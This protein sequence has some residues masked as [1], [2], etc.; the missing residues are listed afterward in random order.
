[1]TPKKKFGGTKQDVEAGLKKLRLLQKEQQEFE[2]KERASGDIKL[3]AS[4]EGII[5]DYA[6]RPRILH[7]SPQTH[8][9]AK[10][11]IIEAGYPF[12]EFLRL[13]RPGT[14]CCISSL[15]RTTLIELGNR[16]LIRMKKVRSPGA[17][18]GIVLIVRKS[19]TDY[20]MSSACDFNVA[21]EIYN[22]EEVNHAA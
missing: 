15:S 18:R 1:M 10:Q 2:Q 13:P 6:A 8:P 21:D 4:A 3:R 11:T 19:L 9:N 17:T 12:A 20:L 7:H 14:R 22:D 5:E 16:G